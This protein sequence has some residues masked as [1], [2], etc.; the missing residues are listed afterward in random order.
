MKK[1]MLILVL[2]FAVTGNSTFSQETQRSLYVLNGLGQTVSTMNLDTEEI[3]NDIVAVGDIPNRIFVYKELVYVVNSVPAGITIINPATDQVVNN[4][5]L[6]EG[7]NPWS[8]AFTGDGRAYVTSL[9]ANAVTVL[10][11]ATGDSLNSIPVGVSPEGILVVGNLAYL[12]NTGGFPSYNPSTVAVIDTRVDAVIQTIAVATNPQELA[13][14]PDGRLHVVCTGNFGDISGQITIIDTSGVMVGNAAVVDSIATGGTPGE[15]AITSSGKAF[16]ADFGNGTNGFL[17]SYDTA[18]RVIS[19]DAGN[20]I[21]VGNG[22]MNLF[23]DEETGDLFVN[24]FSDDN[25]Q[26]LD[27]GDGSVVATFGFGLGAQDMV[28]VRSSAPTSVSQQGSV[29]PGSFVLAQ[30]YPNPFNPE[31]RIDFALRN[32]GHVQIRIFN[33]RGELVNNLVDRAYEPGSFS[34]IWN[35]R[36]ETGRNVASGIYMYEMR[37]GHEQLVR[38]MALL[39]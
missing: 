15:I 28:V 4:I 2:I 25:V 6:T 7:S 5:S 19:N 12:T 16:L 33:L 1:A 39:R 18:T 21:L 32:R 9:V 10:D 27:A 38:R 17:Y 36:D 8:M 24:N 22:A 35:G 34:M 31:T 26:L 30:N 23:Y 14:A 13:F 11:L 29:Q 37:V 20:P 3:S